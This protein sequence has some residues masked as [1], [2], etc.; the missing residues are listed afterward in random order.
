MENEELYADLFAYRFL[1]LDIYE[2]NE[3]EIIKKLKMKLYEWGYNRNNINETLYNFY[4]FYLIEITREE[5]ENTNII[6]F[7]PETNNRNMNILNLLLNMLNRNEPIEEEEEL[8]TLTEEE[9]NNLESE[10]FEETEDIDCAICIDKIE[11]D[12]EIIK[13]NC[14]HKFHKNCIRSYLLNYNNK[15]PMCRS[16]INE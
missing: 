15:C 10:K 2:N 11:K 7:A 8:T 12:M 5:I 14:N 3:R 16:D 1:L 13:L 9:F 6:I 4:N